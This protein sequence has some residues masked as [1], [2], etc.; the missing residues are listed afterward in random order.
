MAVTDG[1]QEDP[2]LNYIITH[3]FCPLKLPQEDDHTMCDDLALASMTLD[4]AKKFK[5][6]SGSDEKSH[7]G[8]IVGMLTKLR[9]T[10][11]YQSLSPTTVESQLETMKS[12]GVLAFLIRAQNAGLIVRRFDNETI[13]E[14]FEVSP[15]AA[16]VMGTVG[17][18]LCSYPGPAIAVAHEVVDDPNFR[19]ELANFLYHMNQDILDSAASTTKAG[20]TVVEERDT[21]HPRYITQLLTGIL[22]GLGQVAEVPRIRKRINDDVCWNNARLPWRRSSLW[23]LIRVALQTTLE[24]ENGGRGRYKAFMAYLMAT[25]TQRAVVH[26]LPNDDLPNDVL[27]FMSAKI[28]R[29]L[30]KLGSSVPAF[31]SEL[32]VCAT[33]QVKWKLE[34]RWQFVRDAQAVSS[35]WNV[36]ELDVDQDTHLSLDDS[37]EYLTRALNARQT[38]TDQSIFKPHEH[39]RQRSI[40]DFLSINQNYL[41]EAYNAE[42]LTAL[43]DFEHAVQDGL[44]SW[45][46]EVIDGSLCHDTTTRCRA[47]ESR[48]MEYSTRARQLY[49][50][51]PNSYSI[52]LL[53][54]LELWVAVDR[55]VVDEIPLLAEYSPEVPV[56][57]PDPLILHKAGQLA[58]L[59]A[60]QLY[61]S[62][63]HRLAISGRSVFSD[64]SS[65]NAFAIRFFD[66]S[67]ELQRLRNHIE[68]DARAERDA[69]LA[70][71][72]Q[73]N[74]KHA[75]LSA[76]ERLLQHTYYVNYRGYQDHSKWSCS[77]CSLGRT[78]SNMRIDVHEWPLPESAPGA[79]IV[80]FELGVPATFNVWRSMTFDLL[81]DIGTPD[82]KRPSPANPH[83]TLLGYAALSKYTVRHGRQRITLASG[84]KPFARSHYESTHIPSNESTVCVNNGLIFRVYDSGNGTWAAN[85]FTHCDISSDC[86]FMLPVGRYRA[87]QDYVSGTS[88]TSNHIISAQADCHPELSLHEFVAF[89]SLRSGPLLQWLNIARELRARI[90]SFREE[91]VHSLLLQAAWQVGPLEG[92]IRLWHDDLKDAAFGRVTLDE[93]SALLRSVESNWV[94][95]VS[96]KTIIALTRRLLTSA[97]DRDVIQGA[98][99]LLHTARSKTFNWLTELSRKLEDASGAGESESDLR[100]I[101]RDMAATCR[102]TYDVEPTHIE[103]LLHSSLDIQIFAQCAIIIHDNTPPRLDALPIASKLLLERDRR[104]AHVLESWLYSR[105]RA[106]RQ[107]LDEAVKSIWPDYRPGATWQREEDPN[108]RWLT[109]STASE[110]DKNKQCIHFNILDGRLLIDGRPV[111]KLPV[112]IVRHSTYDQIFGDKVLEVV[113]GDL[114]GMDY[115]TRGRV[116]NYRVYF[117]LRGDGDLIIQATRGRESHLEV[118]PREKLGSDLPKPFVEGHTHWLDL[119]THEIEIRPVKRMWNPSSNNWRISFSD[120]LVSTMRRGKATLVDVRSPTFKMMSGRLQSIEA[121]EYL[122]VT[123][124]SGIP[125]PPVTVDIPRFRLSFF[126]DDEGELQSHDLVDMVV[127]A[128]Q[129]TGV[130]FGLQNQLVL[131]PKNAAPERPLLPRRVLIPL[132]DVSCISQGHHVF[133]H[134]DTHSRSRVSY[135]L[136]K[137]DSDLGCLSG[138]ISMTSQLY[139]AYLHALTGSCMPDPLTG[140]TG[141]EEA[142]S[143]LRSASCLSFMRLGK[144]DVDLLRRIASLTVSRTF[145]PS[146]L[147]RMQEVEWQCLTPA[148]QHHGFHA[149]A[150][151]I[152]EHADRLQMFYEKGISQA[153]LLSARD[154]HLMARASLRSVLLYPEEFA[155]PLP[156]GPQD[157]EYMSRDILDETTKGETRA[158]DIAVMAHQWSSRLQ[159]SPRLLDTLTSLQFLEGVREG[160]TLQYS[161]DWLKPSLKS[162]WISAYNRCRTVSRDSHRYQLAFTLSAVGYNSRDIK[163]TTLVSDLLAF[164]T[165]PRFRAFPP[166]DFPSYDLADGFEPD[167][168]TLREHISSYIKP[169]EETPEASLVARFGESEPHLQRRRFAAYED[170]CEFV[171]SSVVEAL[172][173]AWPCE[174]L[175]SPSGLNSSNFADV[176]KLKKKLSK[177]FSSCYRNDILR[178]HIRHVQ[179]I[180]DEARLSQPSPNGSCYTFTTSQ[181]TPCSPPATI[182]SDQLFRRTVPTIA[183]TPPLSGS[184]SLVGMGS[185]GVTEELRSLIREFQDSGSSKFCRIYGS[186]LDKSMECLAN[187]KAEVI[188]GLIPFVDEIWRHYQRWNARFSEV[189]RDISQSLLPSNPAEEALCNSGQWP[190]SSVKF[191]LGSLASVSKN[192]LGPG[193]RSTLISLAETTLQLQRSRRLLLFALSQNSEDFFKEMKNTG[194]EGW[195]AE[196]Y[197]DWLLIQIENNFLV[198][199][200]QASVAH[201]MISPES[202]HNTT[203][204]LNM[205]E[206]KS[207]VIVPIAASALADGKRLVRIIVLKPLA[208]QMVQLLAERLSGLTN[209]R[210]FYMPFSRSTS[211]SPEDAETIHAL[212]EECAREHGV[213]VIQ[214]DHILSYKLMSVRQILFPGLKPSVAEMLLE[215]QKWLELHARDIIDESDEIL[216]VRYQ[217]VYTEGLQRQLMGFPHRW[218]TTQ[219]ILTLAKR[220]AL[221]LRNDFPLGVDVKESS[222]ERF[223]QIR[224]LQADAGKALV[225]RIATSVIMDSALPDHNFDQFPS[226]A[227]Q[228][229]FKF[230]TD[231]EVVPEDMQVVE[232]YCRNGPIWTGLLLLRGLLACGIL[233]Y[234]LKERRW[235]VDYGLDPRRTMLAVPYRAKD[236]PAPRAE[237]GHPDVAV[238]LTC[239]SYYY[240]GLEE[241]QL[242]LCFLLLVKD[243]NPNLE[244]ETWVSGCDNIPETLRQLSGVNMKSTEQ[245]TK[246]LFPLFRYNQVV[247][248]FFLSRVVFPKEAKEFPQKLA[249]SGW[250][251][252][253]QK[254]EVSNVV[255]GFSGTNDNRYLL[256]TSI[257]QRDP[258]HQLCTNARVLAYL[259]R[260]ENNYYQC[261]ANPNGQQLTTDDFLKRL[262][263]QTPEIRILLD[264]G[265]QMLEL[266]NK[267]LVARWLTLKPSAQAAIYFNEHDQLTVLSQDGSV[268]PFVSSQFAYRLGQCLLYLD[269][270]H[271]RGT[272]VKLPLGSR[273]AVTLGPKVTKDRLAQGCMRMRKLGHGHS[274]MFFAPLEV[275]RAIR[276]AASKSDLQRVESIDILRWTMLET[277]TDIQH[278]ASHWAQQGVDHHARHAAWSDFSSGGAN[279]AELKSAWLQREAL[280]LDEMYKPGGDSPH[281][282]VISPLEIQERCAQLGVTALLDTQMDEEQERE[283]V[284]EVERENQVQRPAP[285]PPA[286]HR[287]DPQVRDFVRHGKISIGSAVFTPAFHTLDSTSTPFLERNAWSQDLLVTRDFSTTVQ[288]NSEDKY[289][290]YLRPVNWII[291]STTG[292]QPPRRLAVILSPFEVNALLEDIRSSKH[293]HLH[294][295]TP[296]VTQAMRSCDDLRLHSIPPLP[297]AWSPPELLIPQLNLFA[298]QLYLP[299]YPTYLELCRFLGVYARDLE[300]E[301][302]MVDSDGF[303]APQRRPQAAA[304]SPFQESPVPS[305]KGLI[306]M[307]RKGMEFLR[308]HLGRVLQGRLLTDGPEDFGA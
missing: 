31:V 7:W 306:A 168:D 281:R 128:N 53:T 116:C 149:A 111:G 60:L 145:Y 179:A 174:Q 24:R 254:R 121:E 152:L 2:S 228:A 18:L 223:P 81:V 34:E 261:T 192:T 41:V 147:R 52:M 39:P 75:E 278:R 164:A 49:E 210:I 236:A 87:L 130:M 110:G 308:T 45:V 98:Y 291:S 303:I 82:E 117:C 157:T 277:C 273:A 307:R 280:T 79:K 123:R 139:K 235:R 166:P 124:T 17:K 36:D 242:M 12:G 195:D 184:L 243:D 301:D 255:T 158:H 151:S 48:M 127:D 20:S 238:A 94:E 113:P 253:E 248:N 135:H 233:V 231:A 13:F 93:L 264:V 28:S 32:V 67:S 77:K 214:P 299:N 250:D 169:F 234:A 197:P 33:R 165:I 191:L 107:G 143:C 83:T 218:T 249:C 141:T 102:S 114:P 144:G 181:A 160:V 230:I 211:L 202:R 226:I 25:V 161:R 173:Q 292:S 22:R 193:W 146:H 269:D 50:G 91:E 180:L 262:G 109:S 63:R 221:R 196:K 207:S 40:N 219:Q 187:E 159:T 194:C 119:A 71:L 122:I 125:G 170:R 133:V 163:R 289:D 46:S 10:M 178:E 212:M 282:N 106:C 183:A 203:L 58:R 78:I 155:G 108:S 85:P 103:H 182:S 11:K 240:G 15:T 23:L 208:P 97:E 209:R 237:F 132:G 251:L 298:G 38:S 27:Q 153:E 199:P 176:T 175:R 74:A 140:R 201:E 283:I 279:N 285:A 137:I 241:E 118:V 265:A 69:K 43:I 131:R 263:D 14:S 101:V 275:D 142:L 270:A 37:R 256:P 138:N 266:Q 96:M 189:V 227:R 150:M 284:H 68:K 215:S 185:S 9:D 260:S 188:A 51:N 186:D 16:A 86:T 217:L 6:H 224:I 29:R 232:W 304:M 171:K 54:L 42:G 276:L 239:L 225:H 44:S 1:S 259:L 252:A 148:A 66:Q 245:R 65:D 35:H 4:I 167:E 21:A 305:L 70:E 287:V 105:I 57:F 244:Y 84:T 190:R 136:Y 257:T 293:V 62:E 73:N 120:T 30:F 129:S 80:T 89:G 3:V 47:I 295:Y 220:L 55:M 268:E 126:V 177:L 200:T 204:Q 95:M 198:R 88:H 134:I 19:A 258:E 112:D 26:D 247:I 115:A 104:M 5:E 206:G 271:T 64:D 72:R 297:G 205:G 288:C 92:D 156:P 154:P 286:T 267:E 290:D 162:I 272:D 100:G 274:V 229:A 300:H 222:S 61:I 213:W 216:H 76:E 8:R 246:F 296:R 59:D 302:E 172:L 90:L 56:S 99:D 294:I